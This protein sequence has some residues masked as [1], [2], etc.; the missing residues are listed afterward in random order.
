[1][2]SNFKTSTSW[3]EDLLIIQ[4]FSRNDS[5]GFFS[6]IFN[7]EDFDQLG[8]D[9]QVIQINQSFTKK[10]GSVRGLHF[11]FPPAAEKKMVSCIRGEVFD[12][13]LDLRKGSKTFLNWHS[14]VL[15]E[16]NFKSLLIP[17]GFAHGFQTLSDDCEM[18]YLHTE[19]YSPDLEGALNVNDPAIKIQWPLEISELSERDKQ[20][21]YIT[22]EFEGVSV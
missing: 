21:P 2:E 22:K 19:K 6:K 20:H 1:M 10:K 4:R 3:I 9:F 8:L 13:A 14:E 16:K 11:Q 17:E 12:V 18:L 15:S 7:L 5:R